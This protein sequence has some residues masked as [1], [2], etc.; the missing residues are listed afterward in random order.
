[1]RV[2]P[3]QALAPAGDPEAEA[4]PAAPGFAVALATEAGDAAPRRP[5]AEATPADPEATPEPPASGHAPLVLAPTLTPP[6]RSSQASADADP[7]APPLP[8]A[9]RLASPPNT[10]GPDAPVL[11]SRT[12]SEPTETQPIRAGAPLG[13]ASGP[14][15]GPLSPVRG[16]AETPA[17]PMPA[18]GARP[19]A[20]HPDLARLASTEAN[21]GLAS[22]PRT[23]APDAA[24]PTRLGADAAP[25]RD[26]TRG[27]T[28]LT[29]ASRPAAEV[30][31]AE[32]AR[33]AQG[34]PA[35][36]ETTTPPSPLPRVEGAAAAPV[37]ALAVAPDVRRMR[38]ASG[39]DAPDGLSGIDA[40]E[41]VVSSVETDADPA[42]TVEAVPDEPRS[43]R[44]A[45]PAL[46][47][48]TSPLATAG[49][50]AAQMVRLDAAGTPPAHAPAGI[51]A[52]VPDAT[53][54]P[55]AEAARPEGMTVEAAPVL[56][57]EAA[58]SASRTASGSAPAS[59]L[60][61]RL[62]VPTWLGPL[63]SATAPGVEVALADGDGHVRLQTERSVEG[64]AVVVRFSDPELGALAGLHL[65][66]IADALEAHFAEPVQLSLDHP[67]ADG[68]GAPSDR[69]RRA[70]PEA[71]TASTTASAAVPASSRPLGRTEW[72]A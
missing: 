4:T 10:D 63:A 19:E 35:A 36:N 52:P 21:E 49:P 46:A 53:F 31:P 48:D 72:I 43:P 6:G 66:Q 64:L 68:E 39:T 2:S 5:E 15:T 34:V 32:L 42:E 70:G 44:E 16:E 30:P 62:A 50:E 14:G 61:A 25:L 40:A 51:S 7:D 8:E 26:A 22:A 38:T 67:G 65:R 47:P 45:R 29:L 56:A 3:I 13:A 28:S 18:P 20:A 69:G 27:G 58:G 71:D 24:S 54:L 11:A 33:P 41:P 9:T 37:A 23:V 55:L 12:A 59:A 1:M 17:P 60:P 57:P